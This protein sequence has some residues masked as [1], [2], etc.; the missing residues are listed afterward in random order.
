[1][2]QRWIII[3]ITALGFVGIACDTPQKLEPV[4]LNV[5]DIKPAR[6]YSQLAKVLEHVITEDGEVDTFRMTD[7]YAQ[8]LKQQ[9]KIFAVTGPTVTPELFPTPAD[10]L[11]Y[12]YNAR[13]AWS[14]ELGMLQVKANAGKS[15]A[16]KDYAH[17][18]LSREFP[19]DGR[20]MTLDDI[21][22]VLSD[23]SGRG[24]YNVVA[25]PGILLDRARLPHKPFDA[26]TIGKEIRPRVNAF[27][28]SSV[29]FIIDYEAQQV[30]FPSILWKY[31][32][33]VIGFYRTTYALP[34]D[35]FISLTTA[36]LGHVTGPA[37]HRLQ[38]AIGYRCVENTR[39]VKMAVVE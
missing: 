1:M 15:V 6:D 35:A 21:D 9:L 2:K 20:V 25:A 18:Q 19:L 31:R 32:G 24:F 36:M 3:C 11:A 16:D 23:D 14:I 28:D 7:E 29:R 13:T 34:D 27:V 5:T 39:R 8:L 12:W 26:K 17:P 22:S 33:V 37:V 4:A 38:L 30:L 10:R